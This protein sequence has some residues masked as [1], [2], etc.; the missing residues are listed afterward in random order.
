[1]GQVGN[2]E[3]NWLNHD[4]VDQVGMSE[5]DWPE[6]GTAGQVEM[7]EGDLLRLGMGG[8]VER[9]LDPK[10][11]QL[12]QGTEASAHCTWEVLGQHFARNLEPP[13]LGQVVVAWH[14]FHQPAL[15]NPCSCHCMPEDNKTPSLIVAQNL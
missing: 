10:N 14:L 5:G 6:L 3:E 8:Q 11:A 15:C 4:T 7:P 1:M 9:M 2:P 12:L 13:A